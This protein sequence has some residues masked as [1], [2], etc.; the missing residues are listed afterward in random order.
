ME[1]LA[2]NKYIAPAIIARAAKVVRCQKLK[3]EKENEKR[4]EK[5]LES[6]QTAMGY[7]RQPIIEAP[8]QIK[9][10]LGAVNPDHNL[11]EI[12]QGLRKYGEG[13][14]CLYG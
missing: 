1:L 12:I 14:L 11:K 4:L 8:T 2:D 13:R 3:T 5:L 7:P 9:Y 6:T 10:R